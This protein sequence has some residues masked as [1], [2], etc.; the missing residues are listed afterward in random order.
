MAGDFNAEMKKYMDV[1]TYEQE[2]V[3]H[4]LFEYLAS[5][6]HDGKDLQYKIYQCLIGKGI[7]AGS[8]PSM[9]REYLTSLG[10]STGDL[11]YDFRAAVIDNAF[12]AGG[13]IEPPE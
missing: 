1:L 7:T 4:Q 5:L 6:G 3:D 2:H 10:Y 8:L 11:Y 9:L 12:C 13:I